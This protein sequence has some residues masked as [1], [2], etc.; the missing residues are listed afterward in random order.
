[1]TNHLINARILRL[2]AFTIAIA[3][4]PATVSMSAAAKDKALSKSDVNHLIATA[5]KKADHERLAQY[6]DAE[7]AKYEAEAKEHG[8]LAQVYRKSGSPSAKFPGTMQT[9]NHCDSLSKSLEQAAENARQL[10]ADHRE[11]AKEAK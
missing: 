5:E 6:F 8:D 2:V 11:M 7:A 1:M 9:F 3:L 4:A 10:A